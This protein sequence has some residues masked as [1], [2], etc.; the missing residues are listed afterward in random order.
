MEKFNTVQGGGL[1]GLGIGSALSGLP[2]DLTLVDDIYSSWHK[3]QN[4][5]EREKVI[6]W[7][8]DSYS[9]LNPNAS[10]VVC[11]AR[12][13]QDDLQGWLIKHHSDDWQVLN[14]PALSQ[15]KSTDLLRR[16]KG[17]P[18]CPAFYDK[19][20]LKKIEK[21]IGPKKWAAQYM[22]EPLPDRIKDDVEV[23]FPEDYINKIKESPFPPLKEPLFSYSPETIHYIGLDIGGK[24]SYSVIVVC[25][26]VETDDPDASQLHIIH[27][28]RFPLNTKLRMV[29]EEL[30]VFSLNPTFGELCPIIIFDGSGL[31]GEQAAQLMHEKRIK[32]VIQLKVIST[33]KG[34]T[35]KGTVPKK[36]LIENLQDFISEGRLKIPSRLK[37]ANLLLDELRGYRRKPSPQGRTITFRPTGRDGKDDLLD[38]LSLICWAV[39]KRWKPLYARQAEGLYEDSLPTRRPIS[40]NR[41]MIGSNLERSLYA[42]NNIDYAMLRGWI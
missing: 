19:K 39:F 8:C 23:V 12:W 34:S 2:S 27:L 15:G 35:S 3:S 38:G 22:Q 24:R 6:S 41:R 7:F 1:R 16:E 37:D 31:G 29:I 4:E 18:L 40:R 42:Q 20:A 33:G 11:G 28:Q 5:R 17:D 9:R 10:I 26:L 14:F 25:Q 21:S 13:H 30:D 32:P 36:D